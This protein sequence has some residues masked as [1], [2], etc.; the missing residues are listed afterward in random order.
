MET[1]KL[2]FIYLLLFLSYTQSQSRMLANTV[3]KKTNIFIVKWMKLE[4]IPRMF[5]KKSKKWL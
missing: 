3:G 1:Q 4:S 2:A 5:I